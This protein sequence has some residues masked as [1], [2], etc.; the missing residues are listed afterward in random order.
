M[1]RFKIAIDVTVDAK[2][3]LSR[4]EVV[5][6]VLEA[7]EVLQSALVANVHVQRVTASQDV[8]ASWL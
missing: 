8:K 4:E 2:P 3:G 7:R 1:R 6:R 5:A